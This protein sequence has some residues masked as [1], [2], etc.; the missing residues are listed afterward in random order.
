MSYQQSAP[1]NHKKSSNA[2]DDEINFN[3]SKFHRYCFF[4]RSRF[5]KPRFLISFLLSVFIFSVV[6]VAL[7]FTYDARLASF[8]G[9]VDLTKPFCDN[10]ISFT[11]GAKKI[12]GQGTFPDFVRCIRVEDPSDPNYCRRNGEILALRDTLN[13]LN[14]AYFPFYKAVQIKYNKVNKDLTIT[15]ATTSNPVEVLLYYVSTLYTS[16]G[17]VGDESLAVNGTSSS[18]FASASSVT[19]SLFSECRLLFSED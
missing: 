16:I 9:N 7:V 18:A 11:E 1:S 13:T 3:P 5:S 4:L 2:F 17:T 15:P 19:A 6:S 12:V 10:D 14:F 8:N